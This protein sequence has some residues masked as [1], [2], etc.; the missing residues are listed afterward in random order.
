VTL[1]PPARLRAALYILTLVG[2][3]VAAYLKAKG[4]I[5]DLELTLWGAEV[6][7]ASTIA[8]LNTSSA[9]SEDDADLVPDVWVGE[10]HD[11]P[12]P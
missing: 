4:Y 2:T 11:E 8:A 12:Q 6:T 1:N 9:Q 10:E 7:V 5:G 3:P